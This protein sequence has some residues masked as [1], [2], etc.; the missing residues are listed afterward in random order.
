[1]G[2]L[3]IVALIAKGLTVANQVQKKNN[4]KKLAEF[5]K[6]LNGNSNGSKK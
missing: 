4:Q 3:D 5:D 6:Q 2:I 1:M